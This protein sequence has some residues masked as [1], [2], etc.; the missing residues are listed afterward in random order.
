MPSLK[1]VGIA[2]YRRED[3][4]KIVEI[5]EDRA[6]LPRSFSLWLKGAQQAL[7]QIERQGLVAVKAHIDPQSFPTWCR[8]RGLNVNAAARL[9]YANLAARDHEIEGGH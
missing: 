2:W 5:M 1:T 3:W 7:Q 8:D 4:E 9:Q 6:N